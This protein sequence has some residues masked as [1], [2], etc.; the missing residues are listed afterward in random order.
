MDT[1]ANKY[2]A[3]LTAPFSRDALGAQV[4]DQYSFPTTTQFVKCN[5]TISA[6]S[7]GC[8]DFTLMPSLYANLL[9]GVDNVGSTGT[10]HHNC[11]GVTVSDFN[12][13]NTFFPDWFVAGVAQPAFVQNYYE[14]YRIVGWGAR[15]MPLLAPLNQSGRLLF[16]STPSGANSFP[17][18]ALGR[19]GALDNSVDLTPPLITYNEVLAWNQL[20]GTDA[21]GSGVQNILTTEIINVP[22]SIEFSYSK[23]SLEGGMEWVSKPT[24]A[25]VLEWRTATNDTV[26]GSSANFGSI[27]LGSSATC[28]V[29]NVLSIDATDRGT[30]VR[31]ATYALTGGINSVLPQVGDYIDSIDDS[32][33]FYTTFRNYIIGVTP[34]S[35]TPVLVPRI[36][37]D[38]PTISIRVPKVKCSSVL[39]APNYSDS[40]SFVVPDVKNSVVLG[41]PSFFS[42]DDVLTGLSTDLSTA[43]TAVDPVSSF[44]VFD[45][46]VAVLRPVHSGISLMDS[47][48]LVFDFIIEY[49]IPSFPYTYL[50]STSTPGPYPADP[51]WGV[52]L[53]PFPVVGMQLYGSSATLF[54][55]GTTIVRVRDYSPVISSVIPAGFYTKS[56]CI[57][58]SDPCL[59]TGFPYSM[60]WYNRIPSNIF[61]DTNS[62][63]DMTGSPTTY[64][65]SVVTYPAGGDPTLNTVTTYSVNEV[66]DVYL[67]SD[68]SK[69]FVSGVESMNSAVDPPVQFN[70][71]DGTPTYFEYSVA[72][73]VIAFDSYDN[74]PIQ[75]D[76]DDGSPDYDE[77]VIPNYVVPLVF[78]SVTVTN[79]GTLTFAAD[80]TI[81]GVGTVN[82]KRTTLVP[83]GVA[84]LPEYV[85]TAGWSNMSC[86]GVGLP[87]SIGGSQVPVLSVE[88]SF[89]LEGVSPV[90]RNSSGAFGYNASKPY[91][92]KQ[93]MDAAMDVATQ[94]PMFRKFQE[95][96]AN[97][98]AM[99]SMMS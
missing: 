32:S 95:S 80:V 43:V 99:L 92:N 12:L 33:G 59:Y 25:K 8:C 23:L 56:F 70:S 16:S 58:F 20:P 55:P 1:D 11:G 2:L 13:E 49:A 29:S 98:L 88:V 61:T 39:G 89:H 87:P 3:A 22:S 54:P 51:V 38:V 94:Q 93:F 77:I 21:Q 63:I 9:F 64:T 68:A 62:S 78:D 74:P 91:S 19:V 86:R 17:A 84:F 82:F 60:Q 26:V 73:S 66:S 57:E 27:N 28:T 18:L 72:P 79:T 90:N 97:A 30:A 10:T 44:D 35:G 6:D 45:S 75:F 4:P 71:S 41:N 85:N 36:N 47:S 50:C 53:D 5:Y 15:V 40:L 69:V 24:N 46:N 31:T 14:Q 52:S 67:P 83:S 81:G 37:P 34:T 96:S 76:T 65:S 48:S 7:N 42:V